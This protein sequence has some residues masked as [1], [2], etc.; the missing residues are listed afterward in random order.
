[1]QAGADLLG[2]KAGREILSQQLLDVTRQLQDLNAREYEYQSMQR[3]Q[4]ALE[5]S[6]TSLVKRLQDARASDA[7]DLEAKTNVSVIAPAVPPV[8][9][10]NLPA[11]VVA[12]GFV[13]S[14]A[15]ALM[16]AFLSELFRNTYLTPD[17]LA[18]SIGVPVFACFPITGDDHVGKATGKLAAKRSARRPAAA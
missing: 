4:H 5:D 2:A 10:R 14:L 3:D 12:V 16:T 15:S 17:E 13:L 11:I 18:A 6:Y 9:K 7:L 1:M 8:Q